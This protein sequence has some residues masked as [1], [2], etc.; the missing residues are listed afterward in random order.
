MA[1]KQAIKAA[2]ASTLQMS[3]SRTTIVAHL[4]SYLMTTPGQLIGTLVL[5]IFSSLIMAICAYFAYSDLRQAVQTLGRDT[6]PSIVAAEHINATLADANANVMNALLTREPE[7]GPSWKTYRDEMK[8]VQDQLITAAQNI[9]YGDEERKPIFAMMTKIG[10]YEYAVGKARAKLSGDFINDYFVANKNMHEFIL[11]A[12]AALDQANFSHLDGNYKAHRSH[13]W[14]G[15]LLLYVFMLISVGV[16]V[17]TQLFLFRKTHRF[18]NPGLSAATVMLVIFS[19]YAVTTLGTVEKTLIS[20]KQ[21]A[22]D[23]IHALWKARATAYD[24]NADESLYLLYHGDKDNQ[25]KATSDF[26][27]KAAQLTDI[28]PQDALAVNSTGKSFGGFLGVEL[29]NIT[30]KGE[31][32]AA[33]D[34]LKEWAEYIRI[35]GNIRQLEQQGKFK[36]ALELNIGTKPGQSNWQFDRFD[37]ALG[38]TLDINQK[39]FDQK[40]SYAFSRLN[41][42]PYVLAVWLIA[43]IIASVI[44]MKPRLDEYRF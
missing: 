1:S 19:L 12:S 14:M 11:P 36:E 24:A 33:N 37:K 8:Q 16:L 29:S 43:V 27:S 4:Q 44:G 10:E 28:A 32:E 9:T 25:A 6:V 39:E 30:F 5:S 42:F 15:K 20:A 18:I 26:R 38:A 22:F 3:H 23:S 7:T 40:I 2:T 13:A 41:I 34:T 21:D 17:V 35:D 31:K